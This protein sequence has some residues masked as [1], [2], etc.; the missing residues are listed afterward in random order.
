MWWRFHFN[1]LRL[2]MLETVL[3]FYKPVLIGLASFER[4][5]SKSCF[6]GWTKNCSKC[7]CQYVKWFISATWWTYWVDMCWNRKLSAQR[8]LLHTNL[9]VYNV[10]PCTHTMG[11]LAPPH[12]ETQI[13]GV[14]G[15]ALQGHTINSSF[16][17]KGY[18]NCWCVPE[19]HFWKPY[20]TSLY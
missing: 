2:Y 10:L 17:I 11:V 15:L 14:W 9:R 1:W 7:F 18:C 5:C 16:A 3:G 20:L 8:H 4:S 19:V 12:M 6:K 13:I